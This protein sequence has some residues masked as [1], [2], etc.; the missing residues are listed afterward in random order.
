MFKVPPARS[1]YRVPGTMDE[2]DK[3]SALMEP[4]PRIKA[5]NP[6]R[7][8]PRIREIMVPEAITAVALYIRV[9]N[10]VWLTGFFL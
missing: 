9:E 4:F 1:M 3:I 10:L 6:T 5:I 8:K 7:R 2:I